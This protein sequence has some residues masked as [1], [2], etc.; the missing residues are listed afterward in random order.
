MTSRHDASHGV[1]RHDVMA[2]RGPHVMTYVMTALAVVA[3]RLL[4]WVAEDMF[5]D[6]KWPLLMNT[7]PTPRRSS[8]TNSRLRGCFDIRERSVQE[9]R[10][11]GVVATRYVPRDRSL[12][13]MLTHCLSR[14]KF[15][16]KVKQAQ[17]VQRYNCIKG[18]M[19]T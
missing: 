15:T 13:D 1:T 16:D 3:A 6:V 19:F 8:T 5:G 9:L 12:A 14:G 4:Q 11:R 18:G 17:N 2:L 7:D 10:D